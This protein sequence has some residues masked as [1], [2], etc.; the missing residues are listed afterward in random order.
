MYTGPHIITDGL[1]L[2][3]DPGSLRS[4]VSGSSTVLNLADTSESGSFNNLQNTTFS[5]NF[6]GHWYFDSLTDA[7]GNDGNFI[8]FEEDDDTQG[9]ATNALTYEIWI[10]RQGLSKGTSPRI[11]S[12]DLSDYAGLYVPG[13]NGGQNVR[14]RFNIG[15]SAKNITSTGY[16]S[17]F[18]IGEW[19]HLVG[20]ADYNGSD[21]Y[22][23][24]L[25]IN[26]EL[27]NSIVGGSASGNWG[28]GTTRPFGIFTNI[29]AS[30]QDNNGYN[31]FCGPVRV[32][33][34]LLSAAEV[35]QNYNA[36]KSRFGL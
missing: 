12:T 20:T 8:A 7:G 22:N 5:S 3:I 1:V 32:Y 28:D 18:P 17:G 34:K 35:L 9:D 31:G 33:N 26:G 16:G 23:G 30:P 6:G 36:Q 21:T 14:W 29:E 25:Y 10:N 24:Y 19:F 27:N 4:Y 15:G 13:S 2:S 11:M